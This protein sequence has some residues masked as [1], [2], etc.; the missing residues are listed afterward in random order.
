MQTQIQSHYQSQPWSVEIVSQSPPK[1]LSNLDI[2][3]L[4]L[5]RMS[6][7]KDDAIFHCNCAKEQ[8]EKE[9]KM[10]KMKEKEQTE[11]NKIEI[12]EFSE[13][14]ELYNEIYFKFFFLK[15]KKRV[16]TYNKDTNFL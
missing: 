9:K 2:Y 1:S 14:N 4:F 10:E 3:K 12:F 15:H 8:K 16:S 6:L 5:N 13:R 11:R 7:L